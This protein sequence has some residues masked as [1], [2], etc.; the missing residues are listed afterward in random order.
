MVKYNARVCPL[1]CIFNDSVPSY[2]TC[3]NFLN[4]YPFSAYVTE[5][6]LSTLY[7]IHTTN[8]TRT[9]IHYLLLRKGNKWNS[10]LV[11]KKMTRKHTIVRNS[12][13]AY[14]GRN[15]HTDFRATFFSLFFLRICT[16]IYV[17]THNFSFDILTYSL[18]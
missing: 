13:S 9:Y 10:Y 7:K 17:C 3:T 5:N 8:N 11:R 4:L 14:R 1:Q 16:K 18:F 6:S 15:D 2:E 12:L